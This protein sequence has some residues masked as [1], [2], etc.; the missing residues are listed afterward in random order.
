MYK[1]IAFALIIV[2][3]IVSIFVGIFFLE[4]II[5]FNTHIFLN[6]LGKMALHTELSRLPGNQGMMST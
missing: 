1:L 3:P 2:V 4:R 5:I 6:I